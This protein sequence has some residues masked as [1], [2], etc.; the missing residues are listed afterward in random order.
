MAETQQNG[1]PSSG[2]APEGRGPRRRGWPWAVDALFLVL[3]FAGAYVAH[4]AVRAPER[5]VNAAADRLEGMAGKV[6]EKLREG[7][8]PNVTLRTIINS[9]FAK[10][11]ATPKL[12]VLTDTIDVEVAKSSEKRVLW[13]LLNLGTTEVR[14]KAPGNKVQFY[15]PVREIKAEDFSY[16]PAAKKVVVRV[17]GPVLDRQVVDVQSDPSKIEVETRV[18]WARLSAFS[19][20]RLEAKAREALRQEVLASA[21]TPPM[22]DL[23]RLHAEKTLK[24]FFAELEGALGDGVRLEFE[25]RPAK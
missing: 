1:S 13:G 14:L 21:D 17:P 11:D 6:F 16:R 23:A 2:P 24:A 8:R 3:I 19:G 7:L 12:V 9:Q 10:L 18:G 20:K 5:T 15:I 4:E 25:F 22:H